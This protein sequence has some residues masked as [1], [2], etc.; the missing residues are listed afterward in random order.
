MGTDLSKQVGE[1]ED[2]WVASDFAAS[3]V[4]TG[5]FKECE[6]TAITNAAAVAQWHT[7]LQQ[8]ESL[9][10]QG[11]MK[12]CREV[13]VATGC[14]NFECM[15]IVSIDH[16]FPSLTTHLDLGG[17]FALSLSNLPLCNPTQARV[18]GTKHALYPMRPAS[19]QA[20]RV[21]RTQH[22][23]LCGYTA[24]VRTSTTPVYFC[25]GAYDAILVH[26]YKI[27]GMLDALL[28][29]QAVDRCC[30]CHCRLPPQHCCWMSYC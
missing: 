16:W 15:W 23:S 13:C 27:P 25:A 24:A 18:D 14:S 8:T 10:N 17:E 19:H 2:V 1:G 22:S 21:A 7:W 6:A 9:Y 12:D 26:R 5:P 29:H 28:Q 3:G 20:P 4:P 30:L 11:R